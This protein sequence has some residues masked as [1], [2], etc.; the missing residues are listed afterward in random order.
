MS[1]PINQLVYAGF[2]NNTTTYPQY[3]FVVSPIDSLCYINIDAVPVSGGNDPSIQPST[4]WLPFPNVSGDITGVVAGTGLSG[5]G[6]NGSV[7]L[8]NAGVLT[9]SAGKGLKNS[10]TTSDPIFDNIG[11]LSA[12]AGTGMI[13]SGTD[14]DPIFDNAGVLSIDGATGALTTKT[15]TWSRLTSQTINTIGTPST[16]SVNWSQ[17]SGDI[18]TISQNAPSGAN[19][20]VNQ[21]GVYLLT[22]Q[23]TYN[24]LSSG[25]FTDQTLRTYISLTRGA[26]TSQILQQNFD[27]TNTTPNNS[28]VSSSCVYRLEKNDQIF[29]QT[30]QYLSG[31]SFTLSGQSSAP[32]DFDLNTYWTWTL[33]QPLP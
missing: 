25:T 5:G 11:V 30:S 24:N 21:K 7:V 6:T 16:V 31:G 23:I 8:N 32:A 14:S 29:F 20:T 13:N 22:L 19:F 26:G 28:G 10:G 27:F 12:S 4:I 18:T 9:A 17:S 1:I 15:A 2:W 33:L 3:Y